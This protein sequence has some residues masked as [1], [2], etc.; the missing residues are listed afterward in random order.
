[1]IYEKSGMKIVS[2]V[3]VKE[4][5]KDLYNIDLLI[6]IEYRCVNL[7]FDN[8]PVYISSR[9]QFPLVKSILIRFCTVEDNNIC[10]IHFLSDSGIHSTIA[11]FEMDYSKI[12]M[13]ILDKEFFVEIKICEVE[14]K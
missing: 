14:N 9:V 5:K 10:T 7:D 6:P 3:E 2:D 12:Y 1:M 4:I 11:N 13:E 8:L